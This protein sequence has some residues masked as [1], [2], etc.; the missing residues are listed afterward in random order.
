MIHQILVG[1]AGFFCEF[2]EVLNRIRVD[3]NRDRLFQPSNTG[4]GEDR[5]L[6][7]FQCLSYCCASRELAFLAVIQIKPSFLSHEFQGSS[8]FPLL[9]KPRLLVRQQDDLR[10]TPA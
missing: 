7:A 9:D 8:F 5:I 2:L 4:N 3:A 10:L 1:Y 6:C